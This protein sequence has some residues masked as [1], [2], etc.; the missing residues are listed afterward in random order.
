MDTSILESTK[1]LSGGKCMS[2]ASRRKYPAFCTRQNGLASRSSGHNRC[3]P[4]NC[5]GEKWVS[6]EILRK[7]SACCS[8][9]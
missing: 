1:K 9:T 2:F 8:I 6:F 5:A 4:G 7:Y 3:C